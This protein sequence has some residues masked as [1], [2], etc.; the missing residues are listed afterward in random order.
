[1]LTIAQ[2]AQ[3]LNLS[4]SHVYHLLETGQITYYPFGERAKRVKA[5]DL[6]KYMRKV[7]VQAQL[8]DKYK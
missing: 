3:I 7:C 5:S 8:S 6:D 2:V 1:M 4:E